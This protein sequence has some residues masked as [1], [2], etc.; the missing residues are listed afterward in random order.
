MRLSA[1][2]EEFC[3]HLRVERE[4]AH[5]TVQTYGWCFGDFM[6]F[7]RKKLGGTVLV[8]DFTSELCRA[9][10]YDLAARGPEMGGGGGVA[11]RVRPTTGS[12]H[13]CTSGLR[14]TPAFRGRRLGRR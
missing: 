9:Y 1:F 5:R 14:R 13:P 11:C 10:H 3:H 6:Q 7:S 8:T 2:F 12:R 4:A